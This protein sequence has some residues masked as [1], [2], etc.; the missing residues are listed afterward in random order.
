MAKKKDS[1]A[2]EDVVVEEETPSLEDDTQTTDTKSSSQQDDYEARFKGLQRTYNKAQSKLKALEE[3]EADLLEAAETSKQSEQELKSQLD[4]LQKEQEDAKSELDNLTG[5]LA[6]QS[7]K[8]KRM[9]LILSDFPE[10]AKFEAAGLLPD[11][12]DEDEMAE[13]FEAF[14]EALQSTVS[15]NV[16]Q[17]LVGASP[18]DS[19]T[20]STKPVRTAEQVYSRLQQLAG[21]R[22]EKLRAEYEELVAEWDEIQKLQ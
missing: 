17:K 19:G 10:L 7:A 14:S 13:K 20:T 6:T 22:D 8:N 3:R 18:T 4:K 11:A 5:E 9:L 16:Q 2:T 15:T 1:E 21:T 12:V